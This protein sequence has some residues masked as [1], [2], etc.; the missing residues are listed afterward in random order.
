[1]IERIFHPIGQGAFYSESHYSENGDKKFNIV[2]DCGNSNLELTSSVVTDAFPPNEAINILFISHFDWDH[3]S[4]IKVLTDHTKIERV[5]MPLLH[6]NKRILLN[7]IYEAIGEKESATL[8]SNP[9]EFFGENTEITYVRSAGKN[10][11]DDNNESLSVEKLP[12]EI[13]SGTKI[14]VNPNIDWIYIPYNR[15][16]KMK[17]D[18]LIEALKDN[19]NPKD[20][21]DNSTYTLVHISEITEKISKNKNEINTFKKAYEILSKDINND[22]M[23]QYFL[24]KVYRQ[25]N[26]H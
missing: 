19:F 2:Y 7:Y 8:V 13:N 1:M 16:Y 4:K 17:H 26:F 23:M 15:D 11:R 25:N 21:V 10:D 6:N 14:F 20:L 9:K 5:V 12:E 3:I 24:Q 22:S 18:K